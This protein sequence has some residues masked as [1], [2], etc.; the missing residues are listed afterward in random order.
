MRAVQLAAGLVW[1]V[2]LGALCLPAGCQADGGPA[3]AAHQQLDQL[4][5]LVPRRIE[6]LPFTKPRSF[7]EDATPDGIEVVLAATDAFGDNVKAVGD[8]RFELYRFRPA[9]GDPRGER[10]GFWEEAVRTVAEHQRHWNSYS[11]TYEFELNWDR[12]LQANQ[13]YV[14]Q[15]TYVGPGEKRLFDQYVLDFRV[16]RRLKQEAGAGRGA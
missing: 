1:C 16:P 10:L 14:L 9:S 13:K 15:V 7:D 2:G 3:M 12:S 11:E 8:Y 6:I 4:D 5:L